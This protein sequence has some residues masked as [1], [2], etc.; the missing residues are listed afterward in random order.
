[1]IYLYLGINYIPE[2]FY[3]QSLIVI[4]SIIKSE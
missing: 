4:F 2:N 1:M 3:Y